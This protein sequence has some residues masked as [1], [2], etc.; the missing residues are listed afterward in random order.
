[1]GWG[2]GEEEWWSYECR[3]EE[4]KETVE[5]NL[6][7]NFIP[8]RKGRVSSIFFFY[9]QQAKVIFKFISRIMERE[10][11]RS[12]FLFFF[13]SPP[14][15]TFV[16]F[17]IYV[18]RIYIVS[19]NKSTRCRLISTIS[20]PSLRRPNILYLARISF[21][22]NRKFNIHVY[23]IIII[24]IIIIISNEIKDTQWWKSKYFPLSLINKQCVLDS[25]GNR[26]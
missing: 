21:L 4:W 12:Y 5:R 19:L 22:F 1:M 17:P 20:F 6:K 18:L 15:F 14:C 11:E 23:S 24:I 9:E 25:T 10:R 13:P 16:T 7:L 8:L 26:K 2:K 3:H